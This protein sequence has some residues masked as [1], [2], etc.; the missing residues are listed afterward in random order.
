MKLLLAALLTA[1]T[2]LARGAETAAVRRGE[3][4]V[5]V[6][7]K[8]TVVAEGVFRSSSAI[9]ACARDLKASTGVWRGGGEVLANLVSKQISALLDADETPEG[10]PGEFLRKAYTPTPV[11]CRGLCFPL[12]F[13]VK[14]RECV[15]ARAPIFEAARSLRLIGRL[16]P[17]DVP[18]VP[19][20][21]EF[22]FWPVS[23]PKKR[24][25]ARIPRLLAA[26]EGPS[27]GAV[28][29]LTLSPDFYL[30]PGDWEGE[31]VVPSGKTNALQ[32]PTDA[33]IR[34]DGRTYLLVRVSTGTYLPVRASTGAFARAE[35]PIVAGVAA[36]SEVLVLNGS[37]TD[38]LRR[39]DLE[40]S[41]KVSGTVVADDV[42]RLKAPFEGRVEDVDFSTGVWRRAGE[43]L[44]RLIPNELAL[45]L[46]AKGPQESVVVEERWKSVYPSASVHCRA[47]CF[48]LRSYARVGARV[49]AQSLLFEAARSL[50]MVGRVRPEDARWVKDGQALDFWPLADP[51]RKLSG[52]VTRFILD[53]QGERLSPGASFALTLSPERSLPPGTL[54]EGEVAVPPIK[55][56][57]LAPTDALLVHGGEVY[58]PVRVST[59]ITT[60][61]VTEIAGPIPDASSILVLGDSRL[62]GVERHRQEIDLPALERRLGSAPAAVAEP[63][64]SAPKPRETPR[65][66]PAPEPE[67]RKAEDGAGD[68]GD[69]PYGDL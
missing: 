67:P 9:D 20:G 36:G 54:W 49:N 16:R 6:P 55:D 41:A 64:P 15:P 59:G 39:G 53:V 12:R 3:L 17:E 31:A 14:P 65:P 24:R 8:G 28:F 63:K 37:G 51:A 68:Y 38:A 11:Y 1:V 26:E 44:A 7:L 60:R 46:D 56:A 18:L 13:F 19:D 48:V 40:L 50:K 22:A 57:L 58:L 69:D 5:R 62:W 23:D 43:S 34:R 35:T 25:R 61:T 32:A 52:R 30:E 47:E 29:T 2:P 4:N 66:K 33:L 42:F 21:A 45:M 27:A 10:D